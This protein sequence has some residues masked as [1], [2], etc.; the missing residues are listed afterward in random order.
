MRLVDEEQLIAFHQAAETPQIAAG[1]GVA[2]PP[3]LWADQRAWL[4]DLFAPLQRGVLDLDAFTPAFVHCDLASYHILHD[5]A[6]R[7]TGVI[8]FGTAGSG[9]RAMDFSMIINNYGE[10]F[11]RRI[12]RYV[13]LPQDVLE[14]A[15]F[16]AGFIELEWALN[17][18]RTQDPS[19][20]LVHLGRARDS[21]PSGTSWS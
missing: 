17:G 3:L 14:R 2:I 21:L 11:L 18:L 9:D 12:S 16:F 6:G 15:R 10:S 13:P 5:S 8:D 4:A 20:L 1:D 19:W 7:L